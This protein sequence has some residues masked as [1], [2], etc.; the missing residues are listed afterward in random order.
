MDSII[1]IDGPAG[2]GKSTMAKLLAK[3]L[4]FHYIDT[5]AMYRALTLK[6]LREGVDLNN[7]RALS[8]LAEKTELDIINDAEGNLQVRLDGADV[9]SSI[10]TPELTNNVAHVARVGAVREK[11]KERQREIAKRKRCV[12]EGRDIGTVVFPDAQYKFYLDADFEERVNRRHKE[13]REAGQE[14]SHEDISKD[15]KIRDHKDMSREI[16]PLKRA[17][18]AIYVDTTNMAIDEVVDKLAGYI[19]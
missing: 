13:L 8:S 19:K 9:T 1:A 3:Q 12:F 17:E 14:V 15:L 2:S 18:D 5:G 4:S 7:E 11:M 10:R 6:A 16:A